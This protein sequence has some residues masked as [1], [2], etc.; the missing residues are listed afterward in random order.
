MAIF[1]L[2]AFESELTM[3]EMFVKQVGVNASDGHP[4][5]LLKEREGHRVMPIW[6]G[7]LEF[8][9]IALALNAATS[10]RP[11]THDLMAAA[12]DALG[13]KV[14]S[15]E[16]CEIADSTFHAKL[17]LVG[18]DRESLLLDC[19]PSDGIALALRYSAS[20]VVSPAVVEAAGY[21]DTQDETQKDAEEFKRFLDTLKP[22]DFAAHVQS[23]ALSENPPESLPGAK[24]AGDQGT[25]LSEDATKENPELD[26]E[27]RPSHK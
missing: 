9:A 5:V 7:P 18:K 26:N 23:K 21:A 20:I 25:A 27:D 17:H 1:L 19:R 4:V 24:D 15:V 6:V 11:Q 16:I 14:A 2:L 22:S 8:R 13:C 10:D 3:V 12:L